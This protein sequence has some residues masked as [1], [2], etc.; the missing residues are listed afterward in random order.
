MAAILSVPIMQILIFMQM[1]HRYTSPVT[2]PANSADISNTL[3]KHEACI[4]HIFQQ[5]RSK[6]PFFLCKTV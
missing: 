4:A 3:H 5:N 1:I 6:T 2:S